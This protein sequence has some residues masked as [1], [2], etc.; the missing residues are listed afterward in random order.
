MSS[1]NKTVEDSL[2]DLF[3]L[4]READFRN[5]F[6]NAPERAMRSVNLWDRCGGLDSVRILFGLGVE[7]LEA[8]AEL[9][10]KELVISTD[11]SG[12]VVF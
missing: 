10:S 12:G 11:A 7:E 9:N 1:I 2:L 6:A 4:L 5:S 8:I 3:E